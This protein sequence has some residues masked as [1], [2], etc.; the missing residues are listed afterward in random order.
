M[1]HFKHDTYVVLDLPKEI[2]K[3]VMKIRYRFKDKFYMAL[4]PEITVT[5]SSGVGVL[6]DNQKPDQVFKTLDNIASKIEPIK[7]SFSHVTSF[8]HTNIFF[9]SIQNENPFYDIHN[10]IVQSGI[11]FSKNEFPYKPHSTLCDRFSITEEE[12]QELSS[13]SIKEEFILNTLSVYSLECSGSNMV[14]HL[15]H[16]VK[17]TGNKQEYRVI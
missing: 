4:P 16:R 14:V 12:I 3:Q 13:I 2:S 5:G 7:A 15:R 9:L 11:R 8:P 17:L 10:K 1:E 6:E